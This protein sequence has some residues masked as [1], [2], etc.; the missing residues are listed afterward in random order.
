MSK[1]LSIAVFLWVTALLVG[2]G[3]ATSYSLEAGNAAAALDNWPARSRLSMPATQ[4]KLLVFLHPECPCSKATLGE[5]NV[6]LHRHL[7][8]ID[9]EI[10]FSTPHTN[11]ADVRESTLWKA[12]SEISN[13]DLSADGGETARLFGATTSGEVLLYSHDGRMLFQGGITAARGQ[14][15][16]NRGR[17]LVGQLLDRHRS[18]PQSNPVF[19][20]PLFDAGA[21]R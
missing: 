18:R 20:C 19:G 4:P 21:D 8:R 5:L 3:F 10:V 1:R 9:A 17:T 2:S 13:V 14:H 12:A 15:G 6:L 7:N 16:D 11:V